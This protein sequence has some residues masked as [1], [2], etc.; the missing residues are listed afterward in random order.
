MSSK[1]PASGPL[2]NV[3]RT[4]GCKAHRIFQLRQ[5]PQCTFVHED[6]EHRRIDNTRPQTTAA[7]GFQGPGSLRGQLLRWLLIP[8]V[9]LLGLN[10]FLSN[11]AAVATANQAYDRLLI[12]SV[13]AIANEVEWSNGETRVDLPYVALELFE[14]NMQERIFYRVDSPSGKT[15]TGYDDL[16]LPPKQLMVSDQPTLYQANYHGA[17]VYLAAMHKPLYDERSKGPAVV[18]VAETAESRQA[19]SRQILIDG[20]IQQGFLILTAASLVWLGLKRGLRPLVSLHDSVARRSSLD[21]T[22]IDDTRVQKEVRPLISAINHHTGRIRKLIVARERFMADASHQI[23]TPLTLMR[24]QVEHG[25]RERQ[26]VAIQMVLED[27]L[28]T[29]DQMTHL[30][31]QL[32]SLAGA[33]PEML[34][35]RGV[36]RIDLRDVVRAAALQLVPLARDK[37]IDLNFESDKADTAVTG[38]V[39]LLHELATNL[40][41]NAICH[42]QTKARIWVRVCRDGEW[43]RLEVE[44]DGPGIL[45]EEHAR[46][47]ER[48]YRGKDKQ[49]GE[50]GSGLGLAIVGE[51]CVSH[52]AT[53]SLAT[54]SGGN[55]LHVIVSFPHTPQVA[56]P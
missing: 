11:Q 27:T 18:V 29:I 28:V 45:E 1:P 40:I 37:E 44:D 55:G 12:A 4:V 16:P 15:V 24:T 52:S 33:E 39:L 23:K 22:P 48:F 19:L 17:P 9:L 35:N 8:L 41:D 34:A 13:R 50:H 25:L 51:I 10:A 30:V 5:E 31:N 38:N 56:E 42:T 43:V 32:L 3:A 6:S 2:K 7:A 47:F 46:V 54:A 21:L 20:L 26:P 14:S 49:P 36:G 53:I